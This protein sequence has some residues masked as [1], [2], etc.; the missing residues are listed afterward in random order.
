MHTL[1]LSLSLSHTHMYVCMLCVCVCVVCV[2]G[3]FEFSG[4]ETGDEYVENFRVAMEY[5]LST[6]TLQYTLSTDTLQYTSSTDTL[7][8]TLSSDTLIRY[9][10]KTSGYGQMMT[11]GVS[12]SH[13]VAMVTVV[14][15]LFVG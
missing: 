10:G 4:I 1:S 2:C 14:A 6:D 13:L 3:S 5:T 7:H 12:E 8:Y 15:V 9:T 11:L